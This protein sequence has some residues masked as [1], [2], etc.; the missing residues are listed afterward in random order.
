MRR[1]PG[2]VLALAIAVAWLVLWLLFLGPF[3]EARWAGVPL[4]AWGQI[5]L[6][7]AAI[8]AGAVAIRLLRRGEAP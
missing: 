2:V 4:I 3:R 7:A 5:G 8:A 1:N 6:S